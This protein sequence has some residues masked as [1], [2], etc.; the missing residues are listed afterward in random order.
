MPSSLFGFISNWNSTLTFHLFLA[1]DRF[2][3]T[4]FCPRVFALSLLFVLIFS[5]EL[6]SGSLLYQVQFRHYLLRESFTKL[7]YQKYPFANTYLIIFHNLTILYHVCSSFQYQKLSYLICP[8]SSTPTLR[9][10]QTLIWG[11]GF[12]QFICCNIPKTWIFMNMRVVNSCTVLTMDL[13]YYK[14]SLCL[15]LLFL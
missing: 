7:S 12:H 11:L 4:H 1:H 9:K 5:L 6:L 13:V 2:F 15:F 8:L 14:H 10:M 3:L